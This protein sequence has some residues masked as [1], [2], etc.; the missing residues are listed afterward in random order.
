MDLQAQLA[1]KGIKIQDFIPN[2]TNKYVIIVTY[3]YKWV[4]AT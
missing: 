2:P 4:T 3:S 1:L